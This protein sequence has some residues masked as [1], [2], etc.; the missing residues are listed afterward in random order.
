VNDISISFTVGATGNFIRLPAASRNTGITVIRISEM[1][2]IPRKDRSFVVI[3]QRI[4]E[5]MLKE[6][7][8]KR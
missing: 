1:Q 3:S 5:E 2:G 6:F 7:Q 4:V 8:A